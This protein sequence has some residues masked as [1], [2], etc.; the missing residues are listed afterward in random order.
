MYYE[1]LML[2]LSMV[3][4]DQVNRGALHNLQAHFWYMPETLMFYDWDD[5]TDSFKVNLSVLTNSPYISYP[6]K[7]VIP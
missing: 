7:E 2:A 5:D 1:F 6:R 4:A 3:L